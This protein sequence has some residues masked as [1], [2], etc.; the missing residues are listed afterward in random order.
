MTNITAVA[1]LYTKQPQ[2]GSDQTLLAFNADYNDERNKAWSQ[3][4]PAFNV[5]MTVLNSVA[6]N[7]ELNANYLVTFE[8]QEA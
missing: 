4:T 3:F 6:E 2:T 5:S 8:K 7:F 1:K